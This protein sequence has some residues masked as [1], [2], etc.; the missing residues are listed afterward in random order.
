MVR[1]KRGPKH[2]SLHV[3]YAVVCFIY[4]R[5]HKDIPGPRG[6]AGPNR[7]HS[8]ALLPGGVRQLLQWRLWDR[9]GERRYGDSTKPHWEFWVRRHLSYGVTDPSL[10]QES[11]LVFFRLHR[12]IGCLSFFSA[13]RYFLEDGI[14]QIVNVSHRDHGMYKCVARTPVDQDTASALLIVLG[15]KICQILYIKTWSMTPSTT[16]MHSMSLYGSICRSQAFHGVVHRAEHDYTV[17]LQ[18]SALHLQNNVFTSFASQFY[19]LLSFPL[20]SLWLCH[21]AFPEDKSNQIVLYW[22]HTHD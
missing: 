10:A 19:I 8:P 3:T 16:E 14:L 13:D 4:P 15:E 1:K 2:N 6:L 12:S 7:N 17:C 22:S 20:V 18:T 5:S 9:V 11:S 21:G